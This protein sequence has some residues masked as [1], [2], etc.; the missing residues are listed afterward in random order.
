MAELTDPELI[1]ERPHITRVFVENAAD[2]VNKLLALGVD[3]RQAFAV[4]TEALLAAACGM[5]RTMQAHL[6]EPAQFF[7]LRDSF[8]RIAARPLRPVDPKTFEPIAFN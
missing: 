1:K 2:L 3:P 6:G 8:E 7:D 5:E 4:A